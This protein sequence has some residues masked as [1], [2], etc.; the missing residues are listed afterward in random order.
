MIIILL[1]LINLEREVVNTEQVTK[2][3]PKNNNFRNLI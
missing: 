3:P 1:S 2:S